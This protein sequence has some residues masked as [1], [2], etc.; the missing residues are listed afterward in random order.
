M[1]YYSVDYMR[2]DIS[3]VYNSPV[4]RE[5]VKRMPDRQVIAIY[6]SFCE[7]GRFNKPANKIHNEKPRESVPVLTIDV[8][9][10]LSFD[11]L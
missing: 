5:R 1:S 3:K 4:W 6:H 8:G 9:E 7:T 10:Q 2:E 11:F